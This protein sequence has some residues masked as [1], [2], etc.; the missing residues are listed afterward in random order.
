MRRFFKLTAVFCASLAAVGCGPGYGPTLVAAEPAKLPASLSFLPKEAAKGTLF[1]SYFP[2]ARSDWEKNWATKLDF[3][4]VSWNDPRT[5]T[6]IAPGFVVMAAHFPHPADVPAMFHDKNGKFYERYVT[7]AQ[8][9]PG[10]D[11]SVGKLN[12][13][14]PATI[15]PYRFATVADAAVGTPVFITDQTRTVSIHQIE[16]VFGQAIGFKY[17]PDL[18]PVYQRNLIVGDSGNPTFIL[19]NGELLLLETHTTGG[20]GAGPFYGAPE[21]QAGIKAAMDELKK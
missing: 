17:I 19:K 15:K 3:T 9:V 11:I 12:L 7:K 5:A 8:A 20:P 10:T 21:V 6:L 2:K 1:K 18:N 13:P 16:A 4:G 14:L